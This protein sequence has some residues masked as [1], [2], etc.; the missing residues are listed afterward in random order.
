M[1][2]EG[3]IA[4]AFARHLAL[5]WLCF[6]QDLQPVL[7][8][9]AAIGAA[10]DGQEEAHEHRPGIQDRLVVLLGI[11]PGRMVDQVD[12]PDLVP[13]R[14]GQLLDIVRHGSIGIDLTFHHEL[15]REQ[16]GDGLRRRGPQVDLGRQHAGIGLV[17]DLA[18]VHHHHGL[19]AEG[20][21]DD[22]VLQL[23][24]AFAVRRY[25]D[26]IDARI[27]RVIE[28]PVFGIRDNEIGPHDRADIFKIVERVVAPHLGMEAVEGFLRLGDKLLGER[29]LGRLDR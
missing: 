25:G 20:R 17:D 26:P 21:V 12:D 22:V 3:G 19:V 27:Q 4:E 15:G 11:E 6:A 24:R 8:G 16:A 18:L 1:C 14:A 2:V 5:Q 10:E 9:H 29:L 28:G 13:G 23:Q 7:D